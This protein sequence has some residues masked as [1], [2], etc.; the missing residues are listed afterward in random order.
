MADKF[1]CQALSLTLTLDAFGY[2]GA[3]GKDATGLPSLRSQPLQAEAQDTFVQSHSLDED[4][5]G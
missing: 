3:T 4:A 1:L 5:Q 2:F